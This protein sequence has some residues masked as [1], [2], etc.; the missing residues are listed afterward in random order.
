M[1]ARRGIAQW[2]QKMDVATRILEAGEVIIQEPAY[3]YLDH[4]HED[5]ATTFII[6]AK[7]QVILDIHRS[8]ILNKRRLKIIA[9]CDSTLEINILDSSIISEEFLEIISYENAKIAINHRIKNSEHREHMIICH[10][11]K[12]ANISCC[13]AI[14]T[15]AP[16][17]QTLRCQIKSPYTNLIHKVHGIANNC[18]AKIS[19]FVHMLHGSQEA[20]SEQ[21]IKTFSLN[22]ASWDMLPDLV[23]EHNNVKAKHGAAHGVIDMNWIKYAA[24]RGIAEEEFCRL[25]YEGFLNAVFCK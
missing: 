23:I 9:E 14:E 22:N 13:Y 11:A 8:G 5:L 15:T 18:R 19:S 4:K 12:N 1:F 2:V 6:P 24:S 16:Y 21:I 7:R 10:D 3:V 25:Y 20:C 17:V